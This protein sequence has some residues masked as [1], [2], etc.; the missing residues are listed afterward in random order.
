MANEIDYS[1]VLADLEAR[2][3]M[4][5]SAIAGLRLIVGQGQGALVEPGALAVTGPR[6]DASQGVTEAREIVPGT[7]HGLSVAEAAR[8]FLEMTKKKQRTKDIAEALQRGGIESLSGNFYGG[9]FTTMQRRKDF[10]KL[11]KFWALAEWYPN[12]AVPEKPSKKTRA[13]RARAKTSKAAAVVPE[14]GEA[15]APSA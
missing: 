8:K 4:L 13:K 5:D 1:A 11:G 15:K 2:R 7:W 10:I 12:R 3:A 14:S 6:S 9:V